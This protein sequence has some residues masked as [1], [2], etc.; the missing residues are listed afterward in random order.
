M[1]VI[2]LQIYSDDLEANCKPTNGSLSYSMCMPN[3]NN[4]YYRF[5]IRAMMI[6]QSVEIHMIMLVL[7]FLFVLFFKFFINVFGCSAV[8]IPFVWDRESTAV[9]T[10]LKDVLDYLSL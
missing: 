2:V 10:R 8:V 6:T 4:L 9:I 1:C 3:K 7:L 5:Q